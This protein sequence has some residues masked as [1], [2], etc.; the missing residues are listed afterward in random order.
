MSHHIN[1]KHSH[2]EFFSVKP[3]LIA[4]GLNSTFLIIELI[5]AI[6]TN[7]LAL[8]ADV[9]HMATDIIALSIVLL[10][11]YYSRKPKTS[12]HTYGFLRGEIVGAFL[13]GILLI[14]ICGYIIYE[15]VHRLTIT[16][17]VSPHGVIILG[18]VGI[19]VNGISALVLY[20]GAKRN[21][22][23]RG[24]FLHLLSD[25]LGSAGALFSG[26]IILFT[27]WYIADTLISLFI[28]ILILRNAIPLIKESLQILLEGTPKNI[29]IDMIEKDLR[30]LPY[31]ADV[32]DLHVWLLNQNQYLL[33]C[34][35][36]LKTEY[37]TLESWESC[38][39]EAERMLA[40]Q[41]GIHHS[42]L[43]VE[44]LDYRNNHSNHC[45]Q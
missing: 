44:P 20:P 12:R 2:T 24:A 8:L 18:I 6:L 32:H 14:I 4:L 15:A 5:G 22:N 41:Y 37:Q 13:N 39:C 42:T 11:A 9:G 25:A 10:A 27:Q 35:L 23:L 34:H 1:H 7:S 19:I 43:Q 16:Q 38:L 26:I 31:V 3:I 29:Q 17:E 30:S 33:S 40:V 28:A 36:C 45:Q 21:L